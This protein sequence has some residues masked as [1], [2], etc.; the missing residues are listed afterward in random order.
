MLA[1]AQILFKYG[2]SN[3][4]IIKQNLTFSHTTIF[5]SSAIDLLLLCSFVCL[6]SIYMYTIGKT[7]MLK[8]P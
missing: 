1:K 4:D 5:K 6:V 7:I 8:N 3:T 2:S